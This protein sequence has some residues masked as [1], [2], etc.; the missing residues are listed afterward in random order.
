MWYNQWGHDRKNINK[1]YGLW[2]S[3]NL[4]FKEEKKSVIFFI[5][6]EYLFF[7]WTKNSSCW[8][9]S[10][11]E[12][13]RKAG[14]HPSHILNSVILTHISLDSLPWIT[15]P[16]ISCS[17]FS[18]NMNSSFSFCLI[19]KLVSLHYNLFRIILKTFQNILKILFKHRSKSKYFLS[20]SFLLVKINHLHLKSQ[21]Q[22]VSTRE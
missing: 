10:L 5:W 6:K 22:K 17:T 16:N 19:L 1:W 20:E 4:C 3:W 2:G 18:S 21:V 14:Y 11:D 7:F 8:N 12:D 13:K 9:L 15:H